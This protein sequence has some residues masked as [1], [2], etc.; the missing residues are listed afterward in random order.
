MR[1]A[2]VIRGQLRSYEIIEDHK[3]IAKVTEGLLGSQE[4]GYGHVRLVC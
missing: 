2:K 1:S 4:E 3:G